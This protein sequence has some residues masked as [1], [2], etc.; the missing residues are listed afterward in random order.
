MS[1]ELKEENVIASVVFTILK[2]GESIELSIEKNG[3]NV[4]VNFYLEI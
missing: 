4:F 3:T 2:I 1:K